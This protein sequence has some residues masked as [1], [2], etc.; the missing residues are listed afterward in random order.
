M[1]ESAESRVENKKLNQT[2]A[3][4]SFGWVFGFQLDLLEKDLITLPVVTFTCDTNFAWTFL[5]ILNS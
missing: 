5:K 3:L 4:L 2:A 1:T